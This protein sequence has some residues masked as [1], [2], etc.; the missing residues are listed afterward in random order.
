[1]KDGAIRIDPRADEL[2]MGPGHRAIDVSLAEGIQGA[3]NDLDVFLRHG[4]AV[5]DFGLLLGALSLPRLASAYAGSAN[6]D[7]GGRIRTGGLGHPK[8]VR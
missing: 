7:R 6:S 1:M 8:A 2:G 5:C 4:V 3:A